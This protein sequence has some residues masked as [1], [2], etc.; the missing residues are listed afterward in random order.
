M[1]GNKISWALATAVIL[2]VGACHRAEAPAQVQQ[3][4]SNAKESAAKD[5][6]KAEASESKVDSQADRNLAAERDKAV[7]QKEKAAVDTALTEA[8]GAYKVAIAKCERLSG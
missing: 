6:E 4:V 1:V 5:T 2:A 3:D 8:E 7:S